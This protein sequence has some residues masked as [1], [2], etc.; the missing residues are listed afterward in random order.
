MLPRLPDSAK[1]CL[2]RKSLR[3]RKYLHV[4][5]RAL[6]VTL[7]GRVRPG[8]PVDPSNRPDLPLCPRCLYRASALW[9]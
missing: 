5:H 6:D 3:W 7:C 1:W 8:D 2:A 4:A 9:T